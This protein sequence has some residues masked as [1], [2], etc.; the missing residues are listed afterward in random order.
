MEK[1]YNGM[2]KTRYD[3]VNFMEHQ[4]LLGQ[5]RGESWHKLEN[6]LTE[7]FDKK[8]EEHSNNTRTIILRDCEN[9]N[10]IYNVLIFNTE[11]NSTEVDYEISR[12]KNKF[13]DEGFDDW[14]ID[15]VLDE[16]S[17][18]YE[19]SVNTPEGDVEV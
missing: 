9:W 4:P 17:K 16:L 7:F 15:D 5:L 14:T 19:F 18:K 3:V 13:Y 2:S 11:V 6:D 10:K 8:L 1:E 12:I